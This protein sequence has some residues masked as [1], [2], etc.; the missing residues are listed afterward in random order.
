[1]SDLAVPFLT[2]ILGWALL[3]PFFYLLGSIGKP[4][5][6]EENVSL[7][8]ILYFALGLG[9]F[10]Y[11]LILL[12]TFKQFKI[13]YVAAFVGLVFVVRRNALSEFKHWIVSL[14]KLFVNRREGFGRI[15]QITCWVSVLASFL[16]CFLPEV[17]NDSLCFQLGVPKL[18]VRAHS[19]WPL[20]YDFNSYHPLMMNYF[21]A[22]G[23]MVNSIAVAK[24]FHWWC[25]FFLFTA[26][27]VVIR[28]I[29]RH[30]SLALFLGLVLWL[31]PTV[32]K[33][34]T[35]TYID[36]A[37]A[38]FLFLA[39]HQ[40][41]EAA[42]QK[43]LA[44]FWLSGFFFGCAFGV[45]YIGFNAVPAFILL[46]VYEFFRASKKRAEIVKG[47]SLFGLGALLGSGFWYFRNFILTHNPTFP[48]FG[49]FFHAET[50][51]LIY[52]D[53][54]IGMAK[55]FSNFLLLPW[56]M[57]VYP[58]SFDR[59]FWVGPFYFLLIPFFILGAMRRQEGRPYF[60]FVIGYTLAWFFVGE[61]ARYYI[62][63]LPAILITAA[64]GIQ[65]AGKQFFAYRLRQLG[66]GVGLG[67]LFFL[68]ALNLYHFRLQYVHLFGFWDRDTFLTN[69]ERSYPVSKWINSNLPQDAKVLIVGE[70]R[71]FYIDR[72]N[73]RE[74]F[75]RLRSPFA[76]LKKGKE[77]VEFL[78]SLG[79]THVLLGRPVG[80]ELEQAQQRAPAGLLK[81]MED[82]GLLKPIGM[83]TSANIREEKYVYFLYE[84]VT[85]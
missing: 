40:W 24:L 11:F 15:L 73:V 69:V 7:R 53:Q 50:F 14:R 19:T 10:C 18:F 82:P 55:T 72:D 34:V 42:K 66:K 65:T 83:I 60:I 81:A 70:V 71:R 77:A 67:L 75:L 48:H 31:T 39:L 59:F 74:S 54:T 9:L 61:N 35:M 38:F 13:T 43:K 56:N 16:M 47:F 64:C 79:I 8:G 33:E 36:V 12:G 46:L 30:E 26:L 2:G 78:R 45:K 21:Y 6:H 63:A 84:L 62:P 20:H 80:V 5:I 1:M 29:T 85:L 49:K 27:L 37:L 17:S 68:L 28:K 3:L 25:G 23:L 4:F 76:Q 41:L 32:F 52:P 58:N 44:L 51:S 57:L 22:V